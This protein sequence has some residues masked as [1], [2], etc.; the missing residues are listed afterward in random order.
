MSNR[1]DGAYCTKDLFLRH[2]LEKDWFKYIGRLDDTLT[3]TLGEKT[4]PVPIELAIVGSPF[5][6]LL[7]QADG[8][9]REET[10]HWS[11]NVL[12]L[13]ME[14]RNVGL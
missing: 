11:R 6:P 4:N 1:S 13:E 8:I 2:P 9:G 12:C 14:D 10:R 3:Q 5:C 7:R